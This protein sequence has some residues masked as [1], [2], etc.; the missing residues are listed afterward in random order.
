[1]ATKFEEVSLNWIENKEKYV[2]LST[3]CVYKTILYKHLMPYFINKEK[4]T[5]KEVQHFV[6]KKLE[7]GM[8][9]KSVKDILV[10]LKMINN[11]S[12][13]T[14]MMKVENMDII[15]P[16]NDH[17]KA[18]EIMSKSDEKKL[19]SYLLE[20]FSFENLGILICLGTGMRIGE[21][22][23]LQW[24]NINLDDC[25]IEVN[26]TVERIYINSAKEKTRLIIE[27]PKT[28]TSK[29]KIPLNNCLLKIVKPL[30][31]I[32]NQNFYITSNRASPIEPRIYRKKFEKIIAKLEIPKIRFH[33]LRH[34][35]AT[36]CIEVS[37]DYKTVSAILGHANITTTLN[38]YVHP[39]HEQ[40]KKCIEKMLKSL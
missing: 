22:C 29:R 8:S 20:N 21:I 33:D 26:K 12:I 13:K 35:F 1:M 10:V 31:K 27:E 40:K 36:R 5:E 34:T 24:K 30:K 25:Q 4:I 39:N 17:K 15:F 28:A 32:V 16:S 14:K 23:G 11:L 18:I 7:S 38:L 37:N 9:Q 19:I 2:K 6:L 3:I